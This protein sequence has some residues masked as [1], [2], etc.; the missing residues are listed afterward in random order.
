MQANGRLNTEQPL[1][2]ADLRGRVVLIDMGTLA[3]ATAAM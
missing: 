1:R 2:L 3:E